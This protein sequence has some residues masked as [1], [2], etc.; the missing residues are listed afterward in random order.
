MF[1]GHA[2]LAFALGAG[3]ARLAGRRPERA[4]SIG[5][6]AGAFA[7][8]PDV[9]MLYALSGLVGETGGVEGFWSASTLV[10][11]AATHSLLVGVASAVGFSLCAA[12]LASLRPGE[13]PLVRAAGPLSGLAILF[14]L[15]AVAGAASGPLGLAVMGAFVLAGLA[16]TAAAVRFGGLGPGVVGAAAL[17]G[18]VSHPF[19]DLLTG[20]PPL[21]LYPLEAPLVTERVLLSPDPTLHLLGAFGLELATIWLAALVYCRL[22]ERSLRG[23]VHWRAALGVAYVGG[24][25]AVPAPTVDSA[26]RFVFGVLAIGVVGPAPLAR[27]IYPATRIAQWRPDGVATPLLTGLA[28]ITLAGLSFAVGYALL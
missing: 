28:A 20:E 14:A 18:L 1:V 3:G 26:Y 5:V 24:A 12:G 23:H 10:H 4:L 11:R 7:T 21:F 13:R 16:L 8:V 9:D 25:L 15:L 2:M 27:R 22:T 19:G 6:L 17:V